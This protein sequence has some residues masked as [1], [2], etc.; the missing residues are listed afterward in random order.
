MVR[1]SAAGVLLPPYIIFKAS[2]MWHIKSGIS[3]VIEK[4]MK[5]YKYNHITSITMD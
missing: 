4:H 3:S 1:G 5:M 2:E